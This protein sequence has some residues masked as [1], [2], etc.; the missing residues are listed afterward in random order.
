M[1]SIFP[2]KVRSN[3]AFYRILGLGKDYYKI[4]DV[5]KEASPEDLKKAYK[6]LAL[7]IHPD[8][9]I[10]P[11]SGEAFKKVGNAFEVCVT[12]NQRQLV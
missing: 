4:L 9:N 5:P 6:R 2:S 8:K 3:C 11:G 12:F 1:H 10:A 7:Q